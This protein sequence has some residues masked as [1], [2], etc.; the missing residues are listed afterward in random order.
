MMIP[1]PKEAEGESLYDVISTFVITQLNKNC[2]NKGKRPDNLIKDLENDKS[3]Y[4]RF[5]TTFEIGFKIGLGVGTALLKE[6][7]EDNKVTAAKAEG[8]IHFGMIISINYDNND[9]HTVN[10]FVI[11]GGTF[12]NVYGELDLLF[13]ALNLEGEYIWKSSNEG[14]E[15]KNIQHFCQ[16][17]YNYI[18]LYIKY[19][20]DTLEDNEEYISAITWLIPYYGTYK[21]TKK[22]FNTIRREIDAYY[23]LQ[24]NIEFYKRELNERMIG[25][26]KYINIEFVGAKFISQTILFNWSHTELYGVIKYEYAYKEYTL[27]VSLFDYDKVY[28]DENSGYPSALESLAAQDYIRLKSD[29]RAYFTKTSTK[30]SGFKGKG[31]IFKGFRLGE[32]E[33]QSKIYS[34]IVE[35]VFF[36]DLYDTNTHEFT[37]KST[38]LCKIKSKSLAYDL[39]NFLIEG[40]NAPLERELEVLFIPNESK[41]MFLIYYLD[42]GHNYFNKFKLEKEL[43]KIKEKNG[44]YLP[45]LH[46]RKRFEVNSNELLKNLNFAKNLNSQS[47]E[48]SKQL[49]D[50]FGKENITKKYG[51]RFSKDKTKMDHKIIF[52]YY[53]LIIYEEYKT[54]EKRNNAKEKLIEEKFYYSQSLEVIDFVAYNFRPSPTSPFYLHLEGN[55][56]LSGQITIAIWEDTDITDNKIGDVTA[57]SCFKNDPIT[58]IFLL[59]VQYIRDNLK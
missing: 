3:I 28:I 30:H 37:Y 25:A 8:G 40:I 27:E 47:E 36:E 17:I 29:E 15:F 9:H 32:H 51:K 56:K 53:K 16:Y 6:T 52:E 13:G 20:N 55:A 26:T 18:L 2:T 35:L 50:L 45:I 33:I 1:P 41:A 43:I 5:E 48:F 57:Y 59:F 39:S 34:K 14:L 22:V 10:D 19:L 58:K 4:A 12:L 11:N 38:V 31:A 46:V 24:K 7:E 21:S 49:G 54:E 44:Y 23:D 42:I